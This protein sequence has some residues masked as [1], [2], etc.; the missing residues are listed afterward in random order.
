MDIIT[1]S[2]VNVQGLEHAAI[3]ETDTGI[4]SSHSN[5]FWSN[6]TMLNYVDVIVDPTTSKHGI[7]R[8]VD[9]GIYRT[10]RLRMTSEGK[11]VY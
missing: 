10:N 2:G 11:N 1:R 7:T 5:Q 4:I 6:N 8:S 3:L 9:P